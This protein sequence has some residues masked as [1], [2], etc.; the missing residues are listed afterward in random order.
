MSAMRER[1]LSP[2][3]TAETSY[4]LIHKSTQVIIMS[5][6]TKLIVSYILVQHNSTVATVSAL[7][8]ASKQA[9]T[10]YTVAYQHIEECEIHFNMS[11][12]VSDR[13]LQF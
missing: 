11:N 12:W 4:F 5:K 1:L 13:S 2:K 6:P 10:Y 9:L 3:P 7:A 8:S